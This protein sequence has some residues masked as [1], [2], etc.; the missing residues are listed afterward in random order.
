M[1]EKQVRV[2]C[3]AIVGE[4]KSHVE[5]VQLDKSSSKLD[6]GSAASTSARTHAVFGVDLTKLAVTP[7]GVDGFTGAMVKKVAPHS[8]AADAGIQVGDILLRVGDAGVNE[9]SDVKTSVAAVAAGDV[10]PIKLM[11]EARLIWVDAQF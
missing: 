2:I 11:R 4:I 3:D 5:P 10:V 6:V 7:F 8:V 9:P 1:T